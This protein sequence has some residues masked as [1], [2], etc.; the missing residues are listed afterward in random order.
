[1]LEIIG[2]TSRGS[3]AYPLYLSSGLGGD[4]DIEDMILVL[5][6]GMSGGSV[7]HG[8]RLSNE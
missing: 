6:F 3:A 4:L 2:V 7:C 5:K 1:M 8:L